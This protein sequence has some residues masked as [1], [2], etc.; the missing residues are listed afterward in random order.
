MI[1]NLDYPVNV[2]M[3]GHVTQEHGRWHNGICAPNHIVL[4]CTEGE[5]N[6]NVEGRCFQIKKGGLLLIPYGSFY[7]PLDGEG[8]SYYF[9][10]FKAVVYEKNIKMPQNVVI[11]PHA[12]IVKGFGYTCISRYESI[13]T[14]P[15][16]IEHAPYFIAD[17]F[18]KAEKLK[19][20]KSFYDQL[21]SDCLLR[22]LLIRIGMTAT[23]RCNKHLSKLL[24][25]IEQNYTEDVSLSVLSEKFELSESYIARLFRENLSLRPSEYVNNIRIAVATSL[26]TE[27]NMSVSEIAEAC[28]FSD[29]YYFSKTFKKIVGVS[30]SKTRSVNPHTVD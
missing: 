10:H 28:G 1:Y 11:S 7:V 5:L 12:G 13:I 6:I 29:V 30:P 8:C 24:E 23:S 3:F 19:P 4:Y 20:N 15:S 25:Y 17:I 9:F 18:K 16:S 26:L 14:I 22:E 2:T 21:L 27:T